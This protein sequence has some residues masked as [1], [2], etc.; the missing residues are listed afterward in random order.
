LCDLLENKLI[1]FDGYA[2]EKEEKRVEF[3]KW[4][5]FWAKDVVLTNAF[6]TNKEN[7]L[8]RRSL[9]GGE[10]V[11]FFEKLY[12]SKHETE[13]NNEYMIRKN[14]IAVNFFK[15][16]FVRLH[17]DDD[18]NRILLDKFDRLFSGFYELFSSVRHFKSH[19][20]SLNRIRTE[21][22]DWAI[23]Y[24]EMINPKVFTHDKIRSLIQLK[25]KNENKYI[26]VISILT[27]EQIEMLNKIK[28]D[29]SQLDSLWQSLKKEQIEYLNDSLSPFVPITP[30]IHVFVHHVPDFL[31]IY[32]N[33]NIFNTQGLEKLN[34]LTTIDFHSS[35]NKN[36]KDNKYLKQLMEKRNRIEFYHLNLNLS[37]LDCS[38]LKQD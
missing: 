20:K 6:I 35:T 17:R 2:G 16:K 7:I 30:Y 15:E 24:D 1:A 19:I 34:D 27:P 11:K 18:E 32:D 25:D 13:T 9:T 36:L 21:L 4:V 26:S 3:K 12:P 5:N 10:F 23:L 8:I 22:K 37:H 28:K 31:E 29:G 38:D 14:Q 33:L